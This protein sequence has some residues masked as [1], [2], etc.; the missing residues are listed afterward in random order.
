[1]KDEKHQIDINKSKKKKSYQNQIR[2]YFEY[3]RDP[4][5]MTY[6]NFKSSYFFQ[7]LQ[8]LQFF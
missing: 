4:S 5:K 7:K 8:F 1:M 2:T 6:H 3:I